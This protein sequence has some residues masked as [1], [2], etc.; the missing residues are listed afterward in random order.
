MVLPAIL[1]DPVVS[2]IGE[3][4]YDELLVNF[5]FVNVDCVRLVISKG[6]GIGL[7]AGGALLKLPQ[8]AKILQARSAEGLSLSSLLIETIGFCITIAYNMRQ[9]NPFSTYGESVFIFIQDLA[10]IALMYT[11]N[12]RLVNGSAVVAACG[13]FFWALLQEVIVPEQILIMLQAFTIPIFLSSR[14]PQIV[15]NYQSGSTGQLSAF[16]V[17]SSFLGAAARILTTLQEVDDKYR[18]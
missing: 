8:I 13:I 10:I 4:C 3:K 12:N 18:H 17:F 16:T 5:N 1:R 7:V 9:E 6:L 2:L 15:S 14:I 11:L